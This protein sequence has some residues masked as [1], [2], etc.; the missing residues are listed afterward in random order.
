[1]NNFLI[2]N[3]KY[4]NVVIFIILL[5]FS[6]LAVTRILS[7]REPENKNRVFLY[8]K[9]N[10]DVMFFGSSHAENFFDPMRLWKDYNITSYNFGNPEEP[11]KVTYWVME[12]AFNVV[13]PKIAVVD[14]YMFN[15][16]Y[17]STDGKYYH[18]G[19]GPFPTSAVKIEAANDL[20]EDINGKLDKLFPLSTYH[21]RWKD[22]IKKDTE[23]IDY[24]MNGCL[25]YG[26]S[27]T[28]NVVPFENKEISDSAS[29]I[30]ENSIDVA[31]IK[32]MINLC[33]NNGIELIFVSTPYVMESVEQKDMNGIEK[34]LEMENIPFINYNKS[35]YVIDKEIDLYNVGHV[36]Q[37]GLRKVTKYLGEYIRSKYSL[38]DK[39]ENDKQL[40]DMLYSDYE[41]LKYESLW[42]TDK[43]EQTLMLIHDDNYKSVI[44][45]RDASSIKDETRYK[46]MQNI[47]REDITI[48]NDDIVFYD[49]NT[50]SLFDSAISEGKSYLIYTND[51]GGFTELIGEDAD[52][53]I[54]EECNDYEIKDGFVIVKDLNNNIKIIKN[55][56]LNGD[57]LDG[58]TLF[59]DF[60]TKYLF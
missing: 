6:I 39:S 34:F 31:T 45:F 18:Y 3:K 47:Y 49:M 12:N 58:E 30:D 13:K 48:N 38:N 26:H 17:D 57:E 36:N 10:Y 28:M 27:Y 7:A 52:D 56:T 25:S 54:L 14:L 35:P 53:K 40:F 15:R 46:L 33:N 29:E 60:D 41:T 32:R 43:I 22:I 9:C 20:S 44:Y 23:D 16:E 5:L 55:Y 11:L 4:I 21:S 50:L 1:M 51:D 19:I 8:N 24:F 37:S 59:T 2:K 42:A